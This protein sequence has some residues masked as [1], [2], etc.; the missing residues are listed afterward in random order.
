M[1]DQER[2]QL[3][4][5]IQDVLAWQRGSAARVAGH[6]LALLGET[7]P[8]KDSDE[9]EQ[10][11][12]QLE[13]ATVRTYQQMRTDQERIA[14]LERE[15]DE[16]ITLRKHWWPERKRA[17]ARSASHHHSP[18]PSGLLNAQM[19][20]T[21]QQLENDTLAQVEAWRLHQLLNAGWQHHRA[22]LLANRVDIDLHLANEL[23]QHG[24]PQK[25]ALK[26]LL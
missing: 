11:R 17:E 12:N 14:E 23:L 8:T 5:D 18:P 9:R 19:P 4:A 6:C 3:R 10:A 20:T 2:E 24:C 15:R 21:E 22:E 16:E 1:N 7:E 26:I 13:A 25:L